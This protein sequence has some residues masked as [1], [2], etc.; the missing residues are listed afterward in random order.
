MPNILA[1]IPARGGSKGLPGKNLR[2]LLGHPLLAYSVAAGKSSKRVTRIL[3][4]TD[5]EAIAAAARLYGAETPFMRPG[6]LAEDE[7]LDLPVFQ[8]A[9]KWLE[10]NEKWKADIVVQLRPTSPARPIGL[11]DQAVQM[12]L[13]D[14]NA[15][16]VRSI[17]PAPANPFKMWRLDHGGS[18]M[19]NLI[20]VPGNPEPYNSPR[21]ILPQA[22]WQTGLMDVVRANVIRDGSMTGSRILP[23]KLDAKWAIDIDDATALK[24]AGEVMLTLPCVTPGPCTNLA[25]IRLIVL[26]VD[27][28]LTPGTMYFGPDGE[29]LKRFH[30][31]DGHGL[32]HARLAGMEVAVITGE[33]SPATTA[34]MKKL[35][36]KHYFPGVQDKPPVL[37]KLAA[38]LKIKLSQIAYMGDDDGDLACLHDIRDAGGLA[39]APADAHPM[40][41]AACNWTARAGGGR[42]AVRELCDLLCQERGYSAVK[43]K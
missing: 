11:V 6:N 34:R 30:T 42:G 8:H 17:C 16:A 14:S 36:I 5:E 37:R 38:Q 32:K 33:N 43:R 26:D 9:L 7:T 39:C 23:L 2:P 12:L 24:R 41:V 27:G 3:C 15:T 19:R 18:Y 28:T 35:A 21:Q 20:A 40:V 1:L 10:K 25:G 13:D 22:W 31:H 29:A 4:S